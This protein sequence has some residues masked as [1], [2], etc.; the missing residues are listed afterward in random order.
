MK[1]KL[2]HD[3]LRDKGSRKYSITK[4]LALLFSAVLTV[5]IGWVGIYQGVEVDHVLIGEL[6]A[7]VLTLTG[8]KNNF[9]IN[10]SRKTDTSQT[11]A[12]LTRTVDDTD[13]DEATF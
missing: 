8:F 11:Q 6:I 5:Y 12:S 3:I 13:E 2:F 10:T 7:T 4:T 9:G 1:S